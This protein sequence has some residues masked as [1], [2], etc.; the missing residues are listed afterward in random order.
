M[1]QRLSL[2]RIAGP[3]ALAALADEWAALHAEVRPHLP[4]TTLRWL[5]LWWQHFGEQRALIRDEF[6]VH[7]LR[8][9]YGRLVA[10][11]PL[12]LT[13]RPGL[14]PLR[15]RRLAFFGSDRNM[16]E[17][18]GLLC[19]P[20][21]EADAV[22]ALLGYLL[23]RKQ[24]W[25][26]FI[27]SGVRQGSAAHASLTRT[28]GFDWQHE[29][30]DCIVPLPNSWQEFRR[31]R[32]R[33]IKES[34]RKC[35]NSLKRDGLVFRFNVVNSAPDLPGAVE[36]FLTLHTARARA[37]GLFPH[38]DVFASERAQAFLS[39]L[40]D[41]PQQA[42]HLH[43]F[44]LEIAGRVVASRLGF[45]LGDELYLYFSGFDPEWGRYS[46]MTTVVAESIKWAI[47]RRCRLVNLSPGSD[48]SK[49]RWGAAI[50]SYASGVLVSPTRRGRLTFDALHELDQ[51]ANGATLLGRMLAL[52]RRHV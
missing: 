45:L 19:H 41:Q 49:T 10:V 16:T 34:L 30:P 7:A 32:S 23:E 39:A 38:A 40:A 22:D 17:L 36:R 52:A 6:F 14:G 43:V 37:P 27:W 35:Y 24:E 3:A 1:K 11:A 28:E 42:P 31:T 5:T 2:Q 15:S 50:V 48:V 13:A 20:E 9:P 26:W 44:E 12:M 8:D 29:I 25:D 18:R 46:V 4:F 47:E 21:A 33:N 51:S